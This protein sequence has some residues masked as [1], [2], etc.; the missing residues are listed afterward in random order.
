[1]IARTVHY[2]GV[3]EFFDAARIGIAVEKSVE[4][5]GRYAVGHKELAAAIVGIDVHVKTRALGNVASRIGIV[6]DSVWC[7]IVAGIA[8]CLFCLFLRG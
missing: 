5:I 6:D 2:V 3:R 4:R 8:G 7:I 1:M